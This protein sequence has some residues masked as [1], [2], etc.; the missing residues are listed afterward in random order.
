[1]SSPALA[2]Q[3]QGQQLY[4]QGDFQA[5]LTALTEA[6]SLPGANLVGLLDNRVAAYLKL[7]NLDL[8]RRD[9]RR[10][11]KSASD[12]ERGYL[13]VGQVLIM[14]GKPGDANKVYEYGLKKLPS[15]HPKRPYSRLKVL[16][17]ALKRNQQRM[18]LSRKDPFTLLPLEVAMFILQEFSFR[19]LVAISRVCKS[20]NRFLTSLTDLWMKMDLTEARSKIT[21]VS[22]SSLIKKSKARVSHA[23][24]AN[25]TNPS[26]PKALEL[27]SRCPRLEHLELWVATNSELIY[28][29]FKGLT[30]LKTLTLAQDIPISRDLV[31]KL[32]IAL[33][34]LENIT[35]LNVKHGRPQHTPPGPQGLPWVSW[36]QSLPNLKSV[37]FVSGESLRAP[38][39]TTHA[40]QLPGLCEHFEDSHAFPSLQEL[41]LISK[42]SIYQPLPFPGPQVTDGPN[43]RFPPLRR[44]E[45]QGVALGPDFV[46]LLPE[47]INYLH[48][49]ESAANGPGPLPPTTNFPK[50]HSLLFDDCRW[51]TPRMLDAFFLASSPTITTLRIAECSKI[52][53][54]DVEHM[55][56][57]P[58][59]HE[60]RF[61][62]LSNL[63]LVHTAGFDD[64]K[65]RLV[66]KICHG[67][68]M[69][70]LSRNPITGITVR[71]FADALASSDQ[72][73]KLDYLVIRQCE[74][75]SWDAIQYGRT[76]GLQVIT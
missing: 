37:T 11:I 6:L 64:N 23:M 67:L 54:D 34:Q 22:V 73:A 70:N 24:I 50:L 4:Q 38:N 28:E 42:P 49:S 39:Q 13:R 62:S 3:Q 33:P 41:K 2:L 45:L 30:R 59:E 63:A 43:R 14:E 60:Q 46:P 40:L 48:V 68:K 10:M 20:W 17:Q 18:G 15:Q 29:K 61:Q 26:I 53:A 36:P 21:W 65:S 44:L 16:E 32:L 57:Q 69:L 75:V 8:A 7:R 56:K 35:M 52:D 5:A 74:D 9:A 27:V 51:L 58:L 55:L 66:L 12:D 25:L 1:M 76:K 47:N 19:E 71:L 31:G 72:V